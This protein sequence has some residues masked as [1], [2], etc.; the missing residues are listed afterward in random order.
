MLP[1]FADLL[2]VRSGAHDRGVE[3]K[4]AQVFLRFLCRFPLAIRGER[5]LNALRSLVEASAS[6][7]EGMKSPVK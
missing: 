3:A 4:A 5:A 1:L 2:L 7:G 6:A